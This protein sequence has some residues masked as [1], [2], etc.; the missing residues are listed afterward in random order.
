MTGND[1]CFYAAY[2][3]QPAIADDKV[4]TTSSSELLEVAATRRPFRWSRK[5]SVSPTIRTK[6]SDYSK[7]GF[8]TAVVAFVRFLLPAEPATHSK[9]RRFT[10]HLL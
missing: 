3:N 1:G 9:Q 4:E 8:V 5:Y 7:K 2:E 6:K 10:A